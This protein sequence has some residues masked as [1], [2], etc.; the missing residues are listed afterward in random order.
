MEDRCEAGDRVLNGCDVCIKRLD[1]RDDRRDEF[2]VVEGEGAVGRER[3]CGSRRDK[4][5]EDAPDL[6]RDKAEVLSGARLVDAEVGDG[7]ECFDC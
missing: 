4:F 2:F 7:I 3:G 5:R 6:L 1:C